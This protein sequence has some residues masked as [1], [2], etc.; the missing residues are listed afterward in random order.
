MAIDRQAVADK[1]SSPVFSTISR[2]SSLVFKCIIFSLNMVEK[3]LNIFRVYNTFT[4]KK[5][6][7]H[8]KKILHHSFF[9]F[10]KKHHF[11]H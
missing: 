9:F 11:L 7:I 1:N 4:G 2:D 3:T 8:K 10:G 5:K 6:F